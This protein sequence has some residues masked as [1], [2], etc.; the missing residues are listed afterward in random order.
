MALLA[1]FPLIMI[2]VL[3]MVFTIIMDDAHNAHP[4]YPYSPS[5]AYDED[6]IAA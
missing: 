5:Q 2:G 4:D 6:S 3:V 1:L